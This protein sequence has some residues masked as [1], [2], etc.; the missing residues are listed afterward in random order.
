MALDPTQPTNYG[1][2]P[3]PQVNQQSPMMLSNPDG[4]T[5]WNGVLQGVGGLASL[6]GNYANGQN[7]NQSISQA[8]NSGHLTQ[9][10]F[11]NAGG[12]ASAGPGQLNSGIAPGSQQLFNNATGFANQ[13]LGGA[14]QANQQ[15]LPNNVLGGFNTYQNNFNN[16]QQ[17]LSGLFG[18]IGGELGQNQQLGQAGSN[19]LNNGLT[20]AA[21]AAAMNQLGQAQSS[22]GD[23]YNNSLKNIMAGIQPGR[24]QQ[25]AA[26]NDAQFQRGQLGSSGGA[27]QTRAMYQGFGQTDLAAQQQA[28]NQALQQQ[29]QNVNSATA[30]GNL[31][32]NNLL[33][34]TSLMNSAFNNFNNLTGLGSNLTG[35]GFNMN[36]QNLQNQTGL[37]MFP[38]QL[39]GQQLS[40]AQGA[41][42]LGNNVNQMGI[43]NTQLALQAGQQNSNL[44]AQAGQIGGQLAQKQTNTGGGVL[45]TALGALTSGGNNSVFSQLGSLFG[46]G[47]GGNTVDT[48]SYTPTIPDMGGGGVL[49]ADPNAPAYDPLATPT[50]P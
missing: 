19:Q 35:Q 36:S 28:Y 32:N 40:L 44:G 27:L 15:G 24:D 1:A 29:Q 21:D 8:Q 38:G 34:G 12:N 39:A 6:Y 46:L 22:F 17:N 10:G 23:V 42:G 7:Q 4:S 5:N 3:G 9:T 41:Q 37:S 16:A 18:N 49:A 30:Y 33:T 25:I 31:G 13:A 43:N 26:A 2:T 47:G 14:A 11:Q 20:G 50:F 48:G 45:G